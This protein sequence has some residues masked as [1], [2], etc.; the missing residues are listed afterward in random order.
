MSKRSNL[1]ITALL[2]LSVGLMAAAA[3]AYLLAFYYR[4]ICFQM[5]GGFCE[6]IIEKNPNARQDVL[7]LLKRTDENIFFN[8]SQEHILSKLG[9]DPSN[10]GITDTAIV[11]SAAFVFLAGGI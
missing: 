7:G 5:L 1:K 2:V 10:L 9:Y 11:W 4:H 6:S 8:K 3:T